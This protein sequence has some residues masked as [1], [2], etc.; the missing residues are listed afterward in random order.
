MSG[1]AVKLPV[2]GWL[3]VAAT[4]VQRIPV[5]V[6]SGERVAGGLAGVIG[7]AG[8]IGVV[9]VSAKVA[10][11]LPARVIETVQVPMPEHPSPFQPVKVLVPLGV[12]VRVAVVSSSKTVEQVAVHA[13]PVGSEVIV[14]FP[15]PAL[16]VVNDHVMSNGEAIETTPLDR[17]VAT[18]DESPPELE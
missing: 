7:A 16:I 15:E 18:L 12:A 14:P 5:G 1:V 4:A 10:V 2:I 17:L 8:V 6:V 9:G 3:V 13:T 11:T